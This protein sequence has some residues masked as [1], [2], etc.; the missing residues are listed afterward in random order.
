MM[1]NF[2][3]L[4]LVLRLSNGSSIVTVVAVWAEG[5]VGVGATFYFSLPIEMK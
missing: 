1:K 5:E 4:E 3:A 2:M